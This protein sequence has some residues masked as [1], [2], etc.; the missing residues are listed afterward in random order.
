MDGNHSR[1]KA[2][3]LRVT[4]L[5]M[6]HFDTN[7]LIEATVAGS[8][9]HAQFRVWSSSKEAFGISSV[10]WAE[11]LCGPLGAAGEFLA[12]QIFPKPEPFFASDAAMAAGLFNQTGR[13]S[14][15]LADCMIASVAIRC[16]AK[17]ATHNTADFVLFQQFGLILA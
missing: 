5:V 6:I 2:L 13:R 4:A 10:A 7:F 9:A 3:A 17:L 11:Y 1:G 14:R 15:S 8:P 16:H 12:Q